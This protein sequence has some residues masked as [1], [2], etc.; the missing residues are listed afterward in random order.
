VIRIVGERAVMNSPRQTNAVLESAHRHS[1]SHRDEIAASD[2]CGCFHC[3]KTFLP[4]EIRDWI[5]ERDGGATARCPRCGID[6]V[7]GSRAGFPLTKEFLQEMRR[8][9]I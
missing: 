4:S 5:T 1:S 9:F 8:Y 7:I 2:L 6:S 3:R